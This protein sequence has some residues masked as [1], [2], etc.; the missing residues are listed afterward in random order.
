M[1]RDRPVPYQTPTPRRLSLLSLAIASALALGGAHACISKDAPPGRTPDIGDA[2]NAYRL[3]TLT[4]DVAAMAD[5]VTDD[6]MLVNS[7]SSMQ[8]RE[9]Y[10]ADFEL[11]GFRIHSYVLAE[12][13]LKELAG[14]ALTGGLLNLEWT[15]EGRLYRRN[16]RLVHVWTLREGRWR[17]LYTQLTRIP[18]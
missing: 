17:I 15:Q 10:L 4:N 14:S 8:D 2:V 7:D 5:L 13:F 12:P 6:F 16:L 9:S 1:R 3:A 11:P 18:E